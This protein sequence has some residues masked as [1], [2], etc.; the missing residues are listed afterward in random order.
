MAYETEKARLLELL[1]GSTGITR[2]RNATLAREADKRA[3]E[4]FEEVGFL[5]QPD[6]TFKGIS[7]PS[8]AQRRA[9]LGEGW[10]NIGTSE[11]ALWTYLRV[12][13]VLSAASGWL[14]SKPHLAELINTAYKYWD[15]GIFTY[16]PEG[17]TAEL[18]RRWYF[19]IWFS[20]DVPVITPPPAGDGG[21]TELPNLKNFKTDCGTFQINPN[22]NLRTEANLNANTIIRATA[23]GSTERFTAIGTT[24]GAAFSGSN[25]WRVGWMNHP[26]RQPTWTYVHSLLT[27][28]V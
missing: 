27:K 24:E 6:G 19:I 5:P 21:P 20:T 17:S 12:D 7:H 13:P 1:T 25:L 15:I 26:N 16:M 8:A 14:G 2:Q 9:R 28:K 4:A 22:V 3:Y 11:I 23:T 10:E 18:H